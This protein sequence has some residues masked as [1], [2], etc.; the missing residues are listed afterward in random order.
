MLC[1]KPLL[2]KHFKLFVLYL[3]SSVKNAD[4]LVLELESMF[5]ICEGSSQI[6][7]KA[8]H[9]ASEIYEAIDLE[10]CL[11]LD[12]NAIVTKAPEIYI[13]SSLPVWSVE[14]FIQRYRLENSFASSNSPILLYQQSHQ[15]SF[16]FAKDKDSAKY[17]IR[18]RMPIIKKL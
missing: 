13:G 7:E 5:T 15:L 16:P 8:R 9:W 6:F 11:E 14:Q 17:M 12:I 4:D 3:A 18:N 1:L 10:C 2:G